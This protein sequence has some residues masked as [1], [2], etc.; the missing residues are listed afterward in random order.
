VEWVNQM[1]GLVWVITGGDNEVKNHETTSTPMEW[2]ALDQSNAASRNS[3]FLT[4][5]FQNKQLRYESKQVATAAAATLRDAM[6]L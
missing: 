3:C 4:I 6:S 5:F 2:N 1:L